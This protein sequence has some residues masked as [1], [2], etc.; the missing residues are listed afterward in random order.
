MGT[1]AEFYCGPCVVC[2]RYIDRHSWECANVVATVQSEG[3]VLCH[4]EHIGPGP[5]TD[6]YEEAVRLIAEATARLLKGEG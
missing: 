1:D 2:G 4:A 3:V 5:G 6:S